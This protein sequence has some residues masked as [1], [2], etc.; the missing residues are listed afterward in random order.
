MELPGLQ[1]KMYPFYF[2]FPALIIYTVIFVIPTF[3][4]FFYSFTHWTLKDWTFIGF[5]NYRTFFSEPSLRIGLTN[6]LIYGFGTCAGKVVIAL[7]LAVLLTKEMKVQQY[8][9][10]V[11]FFPTMLSALAVG[12]TFKSLMHPSRGLINTALALVGIHGPNWLTN[13]HLALFSVMGIDV[14]KGLGVST[15]IYITGIQSI[16]RDY[17]EV[18]RIDG[19]SG[20]QI[21]RYITLPMI[22]TSMNSVITLSLIAGLRNFDLMWATTG[23]GPGFATELMTTVTYRMFASGLYGLSTVGNVVLFLIIMAI[24]FPLYGYLGKKEVEG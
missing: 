7:L 5:D 15:L 20:R 16:S 21:F 6:T 17:Y 14:W 23:G 8:L 1:K 10:T 4:S 13:E 24:A 22:R 2:I 19:A 9:R 11:I 18:A 3:G 12:L